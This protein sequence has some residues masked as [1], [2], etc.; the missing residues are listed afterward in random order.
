VLAE[1]GDSL[2]GIPLEYDPAHM[3]PR[4][5]YHGGASLYPEGGLTSYEWTATIQVDRPGNLHALHLDP[6]GNSAILA[7]LWPV[8]KCHSH[9]ELRDRGLSWPWIGAGAITGES[10]GLGNSANS[11]IGVAGGCR[12]P[13]FGPEGHGRLRADRGLQVMTAYQL[14]H[15]A[16][17]WHGRCPTRPFVS[18]RQACVI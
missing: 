15:A 11:G 4:Q 2:R 3:L 13:R 1:V 8:V 5:A 7:P 9:K 10:H 6:A 12:S 17:R 16:W 14:A 18:F